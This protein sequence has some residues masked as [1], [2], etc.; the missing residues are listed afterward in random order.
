MYFQY[1]TPNAIVKGGGS[2][3]GCTPIACSG[4]L[5]AFHKGLSHKR[6]LS[7]VRTLPG[8]DLLGLHDAF[9]IAGI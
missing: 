8:L 2:H 1:G 9:L 3:G 4:S 7:F 6:P 5:S